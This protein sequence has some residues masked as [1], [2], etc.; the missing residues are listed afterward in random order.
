MAKGNDG[1]SVGFLAELRRRRVLPVAGAYIAIAWLVIEIASFLL[2]QAGAPGWSTRLLA[3]VFIVAFPVAVVLAWVVQVGPDGRRHIDSS[4][5]QRNAVL[6][7]ILLGVIATAGLSWLILPRIDDAPDYEPIPNS[8]AILPLAGDDATPNVRTVGET[9]LIALKEGLAQSRQVN[10]VTLTFDDRPVDLAAFG[11]DFRVASLLVGRIVQ[12]A[13]GLQIDMQLLDVG[14]DRVSWSRSFQWDSTRIRETGTTIAN[15]VLEAMGFAAISEDEFAGTANR[16][17]YDALLE[18]FELQGSMA[19]QDQL[20]AIEAFQ[21]AIELDPRYLRAYVGLAQT[22]YIYFYSGPPEEE[23]EVLRRR[24]LD[25]IDTAL[26]LDDQS[27]YA[28]SMAG[29]WEQ[30]TALKIQAYRRA[31]DL[32]PHFGMTYFR[33]G[34][35]MWGEGNLPEAE[36]LIRKALEYYPMSGNQRGDLAWLLFQQGRREEAVAEINRAIANNP[37]HV[38]NYVKFAN[39]SSDP[40]ERIRLLRKAFELD[41]GRGMTAAQISQEYATLGAKEETL[42]WARVATEASPTDPWAWS[43]SMFALIDIEET[44]LAMNY[45][46]R[47]LELDPGNRFALRE[48]GA[49]QIAAGNAEAALRLWQVSHPSIAT[50]EVET[51]DMSNHRIVIDLA[52]NLLQAGETGWAHELLD[53]LLQENAEGLQTDPYYRVLAYA[54]L[55]RRDEVLEVLQSTVDGSNPILEEDAM[56]L[57]RPEFGFLRDDPEF[58]AILEG[59]PQLDRQGALR[60]LRE[61]ERNG[62][63]PPAPDLPT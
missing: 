19:S 60:R 16:E 11:R 55:G 54:L 41:P 58:Q 12:V 45:A 33:L 51:V 42:A 53:H 28:I 52:V 15:G 7:A 20:L 21:R 10:Q 6:G 31:L 57:T 5:G 59:A 37:R 40:V 43:G 25:A 48:L 35:L 9:M 44:D 49:M 18:G 61:L 29:L 62:E 22:I 50:R 27:A 47:A 26:Q 2:G 17:A 63:I 46:K 39:M 56:L 14:R 3:I 13:G 24:A 8:V 1:S 30:N 23:R 36:R 34:M 32:D 4:R 38:G